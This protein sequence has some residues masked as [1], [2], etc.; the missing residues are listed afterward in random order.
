MSRWRARYSRLSVTYQVQPGDVLDRAARRLDHRRDV[1]QGL[2][3]LAHEIV[4]LEPALGGP[5]DLARDVQRPALRHH[6]VG[7]ALGR[8]PALGL[9]GAGAAGHAAHDA[10]LRRKRWTL[11]DS[12]FGSASAKT[13][14]RGYL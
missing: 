13:T 10:A 12:V 5:A 3:R 11:P 1:G 8:R 14:R 7:V 2:P 9:D 6:A 4:R